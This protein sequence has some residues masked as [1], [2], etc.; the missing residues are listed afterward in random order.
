MNKKLLAFM[1]IGI[2]FISF[3]S[4][5][6]LDIKTK[7]TDK[8]SYTLDKKIIPYNNLWSVYNPIE[9]RSIF[10]KTKLKVALTKHTETCGQDCF[11]TMEIYL[12]DEGTLVDEIEF[13]TLQPNGEWFEQDIRSYQFEY[14]GNINDYK[15]V[16]S[17]GEEI[18]NLNGTSYTPQTCNQVLTG[19][20]E[21]WINYKEGQIVNAGEYILRLN[22]NKK[23]SRTVDWII[24]TKGETLNELAVWGNISEGD[25]AEVI[26]NSPADSST[27]YTNNVQFNATANI[28]GGATLTNMSLWTNETGSWVGYNYTSGTEIGNGLAYSAGVSPYN[29]VTNYYKL[30]ESSGNAVD[31]TG[32]T[33]LVA[34]GSLNY[35]Q[36]GKIN[37]AISANG[38]VA[39]VFNGTTTNWNANT[40]SVSLWFKGVNIGDGYGF[41]G[42]EQVTGQFNAGIRISQNTTGVLAFVYD[43]AYTPNAYSPLTPDT[44]YHHIVAVYND[45]NIQLWVDGVNSANGT[46]DGRSL[47]ESTGFYLYSGGGNPQTGEFIMDEVSI[48]NRSLTGTEVQALYGSSINKTQTFNRS[49]NSGD[50]IKWNVQACDSDGDCGFAPANRTFEIETSPPT[51][52]IIAPESTIE[53][54]AIG[55]NLWLNTTITDTNLDMCWYEYNLTNTTFSCTSGSRANETFA[56]VTGNQSITVWAND[57]LGNTNSSSTSWIYNFLETATSQ[58]TNVFETKN[59][60]FGINVSTGLTI[61]SFS[62][63]LSYNGTSYTTDSSCSGG[64]CE[65]TAQIDIPLLNTGQTTENKTFYW[66][67]SIFNGTSTS[68]INTSTRTQNVTAINF[69]E[70]GT[71]PT[72]VNFTTH[73]EVD[74]SALTANF[75]AYFKY[76]LGTGTEFKQANSS[77]T[78]GSVYDFCIDQNESFIVTSRIDLSASGFEDRTYDLVK[79]TYTNTTILQPLYLLNSTLSSNIIIEVKDPGLVAQPDILVNISRFYP[80][81]GQFYP[82]EMQITDEFGQIVAKLVENDVK[83]RFQFYSLSGNLLKTSDLIA[84]ACRSTFCVLPFILES[85]T[86]DFERFSNL[87][88]YTSSLVFDNSTNVFTFAW[89]DQRGETATTRLEVTRYLLNSSTLVCNTSSTSILSTLTC[90]VG[91]QKASYKAQVFRIAGGKEVRIALLNIKVGDAASTYGVEG[92][93]WVFILLMV[94]LGIGAYSPTAGAILYGAGFIFFGLMGIISMPLPVFFANTVIVALFIWAFKT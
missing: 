23:N 79:Q 75:N 51:I 73:K 87:T 89:D 56:T 53:S 10:G 20:H 30:D 76:Y 12:P 58:D 84:I 70:C 50:I 45:P 31:S 2:F 67:L 92:L 64:N 35:S 26:L 47:I 22:G 94:A 42:N 34:V 29:P 82:V 7:F 9:I 80:G 44:D 27:Q 74:R 72:A 36:T 62:A 60:S 1:I 69:A 21:G 52:S 59:Y 63:F 19:T 17:L 91:S 54:H 78:G 16:C 77:Q 65:I 11:S 49:Y 32:L 90:S 4:A 6:V 25:E 3:A 18:I 93:F 61:N 48:F 28:T 57:T 68:N 66:K 13:K 71:I 86:D 88:T 5:G 55:D 37:T 33:N 81:E 8:T 39:N 40:M 38:A 41:M 83:Y 24:K 46:W 14:W 43:D 85:T 15:T